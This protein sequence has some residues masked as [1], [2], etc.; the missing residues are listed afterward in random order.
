M[1]KV[2]DAVVYPTHGVGKIVKIEKK[3]ILEKKTKYYIIEFINNNIKIMVPVEK[4]DEIGIRAVIKSSKIPKVLK[5][6]KERATAFD[7]DWKTRFQINNDKIKT[8]S[9]FEIAKVVKDLYK[10]NKRKELSLMERKLY[11]NAYSHLITEIAI[12]KKSGFEKVEKLVNK[13]LS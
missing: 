7:D 10:R 4:S 9:I 5:I 12:T 2:N 11:D 13:I 8:G 6:L 3:A 1:Y